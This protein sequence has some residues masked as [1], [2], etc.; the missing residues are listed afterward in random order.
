MGFKLFVGNLSRQTTQR[1]LNDLFT[2]AGKVSQV[3]V[4]TDN[5]NGVSKGFAVITMSDQSGVEKAIVMLNGF[6]W[7]ERVLEVSLAE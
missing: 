3:E 6:S 4:A 7:N 5:S 1:Q 2:R